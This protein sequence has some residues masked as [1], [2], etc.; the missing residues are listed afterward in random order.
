[1]ILAAVVNLDGRPYYFHWGVIRLSAANVIVIALMVVVFI[2][3]VLVPFP[4]DRDR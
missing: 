2:V 4:K 1:M 3:A